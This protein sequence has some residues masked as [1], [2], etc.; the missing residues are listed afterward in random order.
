MKMEL[1]KEFEA[2][3]LTD[4]KNDIYGAFE[5]GWNRRASPASVPAG[6]DLWD[7]VYKTLRGYR[8]TM[9]VDSEGGWLP[10][11]RCNVT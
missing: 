9:M 10:A 4:Y 2:W 7:S 11:H 5:A 8:M 1:R 6:Q 3:L